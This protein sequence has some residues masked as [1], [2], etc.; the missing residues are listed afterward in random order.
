MGHTLWASIQI[1]RCS[2]EYQTE[3]LMYNK[4]RY[5]KTD[6]VLSYIKETVYPEKQTHLI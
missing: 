5:N 2:Y 3:E 6:W 4:R 1:S